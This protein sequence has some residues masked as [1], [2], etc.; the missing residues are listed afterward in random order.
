MVNCECKKV[1]AHV[2]DN[3]H[4]TVNVHV[5]VHVNVNG[6]CILPLL[7]QHCAP[8]T[9]QDSGFGV[10]MCNIPAFQSWPRVCQPMPC[11]AQFPHC[12]G[13]LLLNFV[14]PALPIF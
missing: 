6:T 11:V 2:H 7:P 13:P 8:H 4:D 1:H 5:N 9:L 12:F 14:S 10:T 3:V